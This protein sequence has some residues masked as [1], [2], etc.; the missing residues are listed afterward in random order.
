MNYQ[1]KDEIRD[2]LVSESVLELPG[3]R[4]EGLV[5]TTPGTPSY[6]LSELPKIHVGFSLESSEEDTL[7]LGEV[8]IETTMDIKLYYSS[9]DQRRGVLRRQIEIFSLEMSKKVRNSGIVGAVDHL[10]SL[11]QI[12][13]K[14]EYDLKSSPPI[15]ITTHRYMISY[16]W[17]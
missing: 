16:K 11:H 13:N 5:D 10:V 8:L 4:S 3:L 6:S 2:Y 9:I 12:E 1:I 17:N 15:G 7:N 14:F